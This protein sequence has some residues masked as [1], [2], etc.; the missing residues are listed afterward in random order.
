MRTMA[1]AMN[2]SA[3]GSASFGAIAKG[4]D[5]DAALAAGWSAATA[6]FLRDIRW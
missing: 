6:G 4:T 3:M 2:A 5:G 1:I